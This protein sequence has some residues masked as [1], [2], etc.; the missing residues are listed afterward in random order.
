MF[1]NIPKTEAES[2]VIYSPVRT[3]ADAP[4]SVF[5]LSSLSS[6]RP[7]ILRHPASQQE[8]FK[9]AHNND[10]VDTYTA[11]PDNSFE[12]SKDEEGALGQSR[13]PPSPPASRRTRW[14]VICSIV[15]ATLVVAI[16]VV[17]M[18]LRRSL[19]H[20]TS[21]S[22]SNAGVTDQTTTSRTNSTITTSSA[23]SGMWFPE[24]LGGTGLNGR[25][26]AS[27]RVNHTYDQ[28]LA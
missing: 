19:F 14:I 9:T 13:N 11:S 22:H 28:L 5:S 1:I 24:M 23:F 2:S 16:A 20:D 10:S 8:L 27:G 15:A 17:M 18:V 7:S 4:P 6:S 25:M 26:S 21:K 12:S 3:N